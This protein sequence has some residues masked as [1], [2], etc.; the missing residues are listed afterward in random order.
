MEHGTVNVRTGGKVI[1]V[2]YQLVIV[3]MDFAIC[4]I[5]AFATSSGPVRIV[6]LPSAKKTHVLNLFNVQIKA[7][8]RHDFSQKSR[9]LLLTLTFE[10]FLKVMPTPGS[11]PRKLHLRM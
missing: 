8:G 10:K 3:C 1:L 11:R 2:K 6:T 5:L 7:R 4:Q 9:L